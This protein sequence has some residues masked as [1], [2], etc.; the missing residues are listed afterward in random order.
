MKKLKIA[1]L[2]VTAC[3][4]AVMLCACGS[5]TVKKVAYELPYYDGTT[6]R[7]FDTQDKP[8]FNTELWRRNSSLKEG[9]DVQILDDTARTGYYYAYSTGYNYYYSK[10]L[11]NWNFGANFYDLEGLAG[12]DRLWAPEV[13]YNEDDQTYYAFLVVYPTPDKEYEAF[14]APQHMPIIATSKDPRGPFKPLIFEDRNP[15][16]PQWYA[17]YCYF[18]MKQYKAAYESLNLPV[19]NPSAWEKIYTL[20]GGIVDPGWMRAFD[21]SPFEDPDTGKKYLYWSQSPGGTAAVEMIDWTTP[22]WSTF[23]VVATALY[24]TVDDYIKATNG[25]PSI[26]K[27][28]YETLG[29]YCN[30]GPFVYKHNG[31]YYLT[32]SIGSGDTGNYSVMQAIADSPLGPFRKLTDAENG[33][34]VSSDL[35]SNRGVSGP[36][37]HSFIR[38]KDGKGD[39][40]LLMCYHAQKSVYSESWGRCMRFDEI[41]WVETQGID[42]ETFDVMHLNGPT[43]TVQPTFG[44]GR[45]VGDITSRVKSATLV[46]GTLK[47]GSADNLIDGLIPT[48]VKM[49]QEFENKYV[50]ETEISVTSTFELEFESEQELRALMIY[51]SKNT[52]KA[53]AKIK[54]IAFISES[55]GTERINYIKELEVDKAASYFFDVR[56]DRYDGIQRCSNVYAEFDPIKV[57]KIRFTVELPEGQECAAVGEVVVLGKY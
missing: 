19:S 33:F 13:V 25:D 23:Q 21:F 39:E 31:K 50:K 38:T 40:K 43:I 29:A 24:Y 15:D 3:M 6:R 30:E 8:F 41:K 2:A 53:F 48:F 44:V 49:N 22:D 51:N 16:Y 10:D 37:H 56:N 17:K 32:F 54:D 57:K 47:E 1:T 52:D 55:N 42:G 35:G 9:A 26:E 11:E 12:S 34:I 46:R 20:D 45:E 4:S 28:Y 36:G 18:D 5:E 7:D 14:T 27:V